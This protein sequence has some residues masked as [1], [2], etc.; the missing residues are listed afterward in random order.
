MG[1]QI[2]TFA[3]MPCWAIGQAVTAMVGQCMGAG[4]IERAR[5]V[6]KTSLVMNVAVT[7]GVV[8]GVQIFARQLILLFG[9]ISLKP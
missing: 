1:L 5:K 2:N 9:N 7:L 8:I 4:Q 6:V 3:G